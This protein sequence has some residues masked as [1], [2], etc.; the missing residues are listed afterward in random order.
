MVTREDRITVSD[1]LRRNAEAHPDMSL[2][3][4]VAFADDSFRPEN[5]AL[6]WKVTPYQAAIRL[7]NLIYPESERTCHIVDMDLA[8]NPPYRQGNLIL[9]S[10]SDG[11]SECGYPFDTVNNG[12]PNY[13]PNC[14]AKV[15]KPRQ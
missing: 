14:G 12:V 2:I 11:C 8:G 10:M 13:C 4:N 3:L 1:N 7:A 5:D 15:E 6:E 9:N